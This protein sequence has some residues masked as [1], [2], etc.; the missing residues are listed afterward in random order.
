MVRHR[1]VKRGRFCLWRSYS[2]WLRLWPSF[3]AAHCIL[4]GPFWSLP[5]SVRSG[6]LPP[7]DSKHSAQ[8]SMDVKKPRFWENPPDL[9]NCNTN[10]LR[11]PETS[12]TR[13]LLPLKT[14]SDGYFWLICSS[15]PFL[16]LFWF[17]LP[18]S[19]ISRSIC[20]LMSLDTDVLWDT[21]MP[22]WRRK[23][24]SFAVS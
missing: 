24:G 5:L 22:D 19:I 2:R 3:W 10:H 11:V 7:Q 8:H 20:M 4:N 16:L 12:D 14:D 6:G 13:F 21:Q 18:P 1:R 9:L 23:A 15:D 17:S